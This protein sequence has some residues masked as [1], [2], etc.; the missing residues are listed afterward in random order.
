MTDKM[1]GKVDLK[2][3]KSDDG[4]RSALFEELKIK[5]QRG[6]KIQIEDALKRE[7]KSPYTVSFYLMVGKNFSG[8]HEKMEALLSDVVKEIDVEK[9]LEFQMFDWDNGHLNGLFEVKC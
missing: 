9:T 8:D 2:E 7:N 5:F 3:A 4:M 6:L 1:T